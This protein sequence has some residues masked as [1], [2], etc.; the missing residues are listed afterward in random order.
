MRYISFYNVK[1]GTAKT[2]SAI[3]FAIILAKKYNKRVL[4]VDIDPQS[5]ATKYLAAIMKMTRKV[6]C[7]LQT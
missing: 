1:G 7:L 6:Y 4:F 5:S 2:H 3:S